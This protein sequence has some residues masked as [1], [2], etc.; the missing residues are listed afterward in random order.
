ML[1]V[2]VY[3]PLSA[4]QRSIT[5]KVMNSTA[6]LTNMVNKLLDQAHL[7]AGILKVTVISFSPARLIEHVH[8]TLDVLAESKGLQLTSDIAANMPPSLSSDFVQ[9][10]QIIINLVDNAIKFT[11]QGSVHV[12]IYQ[13]DE[14]YW[15]IQVTDTGPGIPAEAYAYIFDA[16]RQVDGTATR[17]YSGFG[18]GLSIVNQLTTLMGGQVKVESKLGQGS[19]FT[20]LLPLIYEREV[21][22]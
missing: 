22:T 6:H 5:Q 9:L 21:V 18:L 1:Q 13:F 14:T 7:E 11:E 19:T 4:K 20:V 2:G 17:R 10:Q 12:R 8:A 3:G 15:A 16:F